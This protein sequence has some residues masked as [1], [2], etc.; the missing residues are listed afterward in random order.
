MI[1]QDRLSTIH[2][3]PSTI[4]AGWQKNKNLRDEQNQLFLFPHAQHKG[5]PV[6]WILFFLLY[7]QTGKAFVNY[8][9]IFKL[10]NNIPG[11]KPGFF[12][13]ICSSKFKG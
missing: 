1:L 6:F 7:K 13:N 3:L 8:Q 9:L 12:F 5:I 2:Y 11:Q 10:N 4:P